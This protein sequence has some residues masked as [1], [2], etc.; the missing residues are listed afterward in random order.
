MN[1]LALR[2]EGPQLGDSPEKNATPSM[3]R[4]YLWTTLIRPSSFRVCPVKMS[5]IS[6]SQWQVD[7]IEVVFGRRRARWLLWRERR[8][9]TGLVSLDYAGYRCWLRLNTTDPLVWYSVFVQEDYGAELPFQPRTI[10]DAGAYTGLSSI[11]FAHKYPEARIIAIEPDP[12][13]FDLLVKN[14][15]AC[16]RVQPIHAALWRTDSPV[17]LIQNSDGH[18]A[19]LVRDDEAKVSQSKTP[20]PAPVKGVSVEGLMS[21]FGLDVIDLL[22][23]DIEGAEKDVFA[24]PASWVRNVGAIFVELHD[25]FREGCADTVFSATEGFEHQ[26][27]SP[28]THLIVNRLWKS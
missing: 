14:T 9:S 21:R 8:G 16:P 10:V 22:K 26:A 17:R 13:N 5:S 2:T 1:W 25:R 18:W 4:F 24:A 15:K 28:M 12:E 23:I 19:S 6:R 7:K 3:S 20:I 27:V 11:Y